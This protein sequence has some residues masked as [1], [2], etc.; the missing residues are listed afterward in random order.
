MATHRRLVTG[1]GA[2]FYPTPRWGTRALMDHVQFTGNILEP[3]CGDGAMAKV[4]GEKYHVIASDLHDRGFGNVM[5]FFDYRGSIWDKQFDN[6]VTNPP[7]NIAERVFHHA[8]D[9]ANHKVCLLLRLAFLESK[10]RY[11]NIFKAKAPTTVLVFSERLSMYPAGDER[12]SGG[13]TS[14]AW[15]IWDKD[16]ITRETRIKW[17]PPGRRDRYA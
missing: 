6:I 10:R 17:I 15:F 13:T 14:Y 8:Y 11:D 2:D 5:D 3:C 4:L 7:Y 16:V 1:E 12:V 9:L